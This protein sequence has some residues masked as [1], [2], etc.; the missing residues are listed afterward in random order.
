MPRATRR[1]PP[2]AKTA[3]PDQNIATKVIARASAILV[4]PTSMDSGIAG[5]ASE[6]CGASTHS[7]R[8]TAP[9][10][11]ERPR[12]TR[13]GNGTSWNASTIRQTPRAI[14]RNRSDPRPIEGR[15][16][17]VRMTAPMKS[18][19]GGQSSAPAKAKSVQAARTTMVR[20]WPLR[21]VRTGA[22]RARCGTGS[23]C[24]GVVVLVLMAVVPR[25]IA[26]VAGEIDLVQDDGHRTRIGREDRFER[27]FRQPSPCHLG[28]D[29]VDDAGDR[30][31]QDDRV[32]DRQNRRCV[33]QY[34]VER[35]VRQVGQERLLSLLS[36]A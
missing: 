14:S 10:C 11:G 35:P 9:T 33:D 13:G 24:A 21:L 8:S 17:M 27:A 12:R 7:A 28:A 16:A 5:P 15:T 32:R 26:H 22:C 20:A 18:G 23:G 36:V 25:G 19:S 3:R 31:G 2:R 1:M 30:G 34:P 29:H 4:A 6:F